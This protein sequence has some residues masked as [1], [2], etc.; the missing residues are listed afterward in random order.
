MTSPTLDELMIKHGIKTQTPDTKLSK[1]ELILRDVIC[2]YHP[3]VAGNKTVIAFLRK[4]VDWVNIERMVEETMAYVGGYDFVDEAHYDFS[5]GSD[6]K[7]ASVQPNPRTRYG[8][9]TTGY[10]CEITGIGNTGENSK[11]KSGDLRVVVYNP[12]K[13]RLEYYFIPHS[14]MLKMMRYQNSGYRITTTWN[15]KWDR[16]M[17]LDQ[18]KVDSFEELAT[19]PATV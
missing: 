2:E 3:D 10:Y 11:V 17:K 8:Q 16:N 7:T 9:A 1:A 4:H 19:T 18:F 5:D 13:Q 15:G 12:H 6:S 14:D